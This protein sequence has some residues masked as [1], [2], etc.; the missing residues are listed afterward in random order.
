MNYK[1]KLIKAIS[2]MSEYACENL[3]KSVPGR[4]KMSDRRKN[5]N[6]SMKYDMK[7]GG[8]TCTRCGHMS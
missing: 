4:Y 2:E 1:D 3:Y 5:C 8:S 6:H 7:T